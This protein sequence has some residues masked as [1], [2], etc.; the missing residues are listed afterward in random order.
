MPRNRGCLWGI[1]SL[2]KIKKVGC[3]RKGKCLQLTAACT[4]GK[5]QL[6]AYRTKRID[7]AS[8][9]APG[10]VQISPDVALGEKTWKVM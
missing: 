3:T 6:P 8:L 7:K 1:S 4:T 10:S 5:E 2:L 9:P